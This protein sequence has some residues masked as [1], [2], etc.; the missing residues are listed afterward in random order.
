NVDLS[1]HFFRRGAD[2]GIVDPI[3]IPSLRGARFTGPYGHDGR[4]ASL[5]EFTHGVVTS[6]FGGA[7]LPPRE[8]AAL[9]RYVQ[10]LDLLPNGNLDARSGLTA[11]ASDPA[12]R[13]EAIFARPMA[14]FGGAS[15]AS[16]HTPSTFFRDG[17]VHRLG[18]EASPSLSAVDGGYETPTLL[19]T[20]ETAPYFHDG[21]FASLR[22]VIAWFDASYRL[23]LSAA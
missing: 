8:L 1:T 4:T 19:G 22:D 14:G 17:R 16:C 5:S 23:G 12:R 10:D 3:N 21:R 18:T 2:D 11:R 9:V 13:G 15:C 7:P 6:E 20:V